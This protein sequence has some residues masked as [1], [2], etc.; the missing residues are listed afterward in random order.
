LASAERCANALQGSESA[1]HALRTQIRISS[2]WL[3][4]ASLK[5][6][7]RLAVKKVFS[8][9]AAAAYNMKLV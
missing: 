6:V 1:I 3:G 2:P 9:A 8:T 4:A 7:S 5:K